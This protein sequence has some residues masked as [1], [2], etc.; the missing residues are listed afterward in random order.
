[1]HDFQRKELHGTSVFYKDGGDV[2][3]TPIQLIQLTREGATGCSARTIASTS[4]QR[5]PTRLATSSTMDRVRHH[6]RYDTAPKASNSGCGYGKDRSRP[7]IVAAKSL[8]G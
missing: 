2:L 8:R 7:R 5:A 3:H 1:M 6:D 4:Y